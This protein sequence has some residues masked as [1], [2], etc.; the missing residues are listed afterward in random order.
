VAGRAYQEVIFLYTE[1][2]GEE[3]QAWSTFMEPTEIAENISR[4]VQ[5]KP[6]SIGLCN[7]SH[8]FR[9]SIFYSPLIGDF[10]PL[11]CHSIHLPDGMRWDAHNRQW[12]SML[13]PPFSIQRESFDRY[14]CQGLMVA[15]GRATYVPWELL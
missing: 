4:Y 14:F 9:C 3:Y 1:H 12:M 5:D 6:E 7:G 2:E 8:G 11:R 15:S 10:F 13:E